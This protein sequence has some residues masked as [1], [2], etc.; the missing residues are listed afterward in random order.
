MAAP[1][2]ERR[3]APSQATFASFRSWTRRQHRRGDL[4]PSCWLLTTSWSSASEPGASACGRGPPLRGEADMLPVTVRRVLLAEHRVD[5][6]KQLDGLLAEAYR[7]GARP[8]DG[9]CVV[10]IRKDRTQ[11][12]ALIGDVYG[13]YLVSRR[14]EGGRLRFLLQFA[15]QPNSHVIAPLRPPANGA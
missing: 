2:R 4:D 10:F 7:L 6:R 15:E 8:Y 5:F 11:L 3:E 1:D 12:R 9:D 13:L 14:F